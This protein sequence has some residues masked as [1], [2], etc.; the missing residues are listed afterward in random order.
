MVSQWDSLIRIEYV[1]VSYFFFSLLC[2]DLVFCLSVLIPT[3]TPKRNR[4]K[5]T[6]LH[7]KL[8]DETGRRSLKRIH[9][10]RFSL[11]QRKQQD[12][13]EKTRETVKWSWRK[14][15]QR[16]RSLGKVKITFSILRVFIRFFFVVAFYRRLIFHRRQVLYSHCRWPL[17]THGTKWNN[18]KN[19]VCAI[20]S[21][22][23]PQCQTNN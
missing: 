19:K 7:L 21:I 22:S 1:C 17:A 14:K 18:S 8:S 2:F 15:H 11:S 13:N 23:T 10:D 4:R 12:N 20:F 16:Q 9:F 5:K 6:R 3:S